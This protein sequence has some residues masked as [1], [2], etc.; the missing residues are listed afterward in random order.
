[1]KAFIS[2][3]CKNGKSSFAEQLAQNL[4]GDGNLYYIATMI[5]CDEEDL[6]RIANHRQQRAGK[7]FITLEQPTRIHEVLLHSDGSNGTYLLDSATALMLN[8][9]YP[10]NAPEPD[11]EAVKRVQQ[12]LSKLISGAKNVV[13]VSDYIYSDTG[14]YPTYTEDYRLALAA[15]D[16]HLANLC[17]TVVEMTARQP[18][19]YKGGKK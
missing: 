8:E 4:K 13:F 7:G 10:M 3:G 11:Y 5:P 14:H 16:R 15:V 18:I 1:M 19:Y 9:M 2:G 17:D 12:D 6:S